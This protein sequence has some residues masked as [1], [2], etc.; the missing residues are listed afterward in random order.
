LRAGIPLENLEELMYVDV[1]PTDEGAS[2]VGRDEETIERLEK[3]IQADIPADPLETPMQVIEHQ[4]EVAK[5]EKISFHGVPLD[6]EDL[7]QM[8][9]FAEFF[10]RCVSGSRGF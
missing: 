2:P 7:K 4:L 9:E 5:Q 1:V 3:L 6:E 8:E 10:K